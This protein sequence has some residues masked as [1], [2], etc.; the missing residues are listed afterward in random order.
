MQES[1]ELKNV[2]QLFNSPEIGSEYTPIIVQDTNVTTGASAT[3]SSFFTQQQ[4]I[5]GKT[6]VVDNTQRE[7][8][9]TQTGMVSIV[10]KKK[11]KGKQVTPVSK[12]K[13]A[14]YSTMTK[15]AKKKSTLL[16]D[17]SPEKLEILRQVQKEKERQMKIEK[18]NM[19][20]WNA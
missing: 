9:D 19:W 5:G 16:N 6:V 20:D 12:R 13:D 7:Q 15:S 1:A 8:I 11:N 14:I 2:S 10:K 17:S 18:M 4:S 3:Q